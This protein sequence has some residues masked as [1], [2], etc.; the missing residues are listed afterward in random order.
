LQFACDLLFRAWSLVLRV[1]I[2]ELTFSVYLLIYI[3]F[4]NYV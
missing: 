1:I 3:V 2:T 4:E